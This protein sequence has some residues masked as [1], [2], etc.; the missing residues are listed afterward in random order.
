MRRGGGKSRKSDNVHTF[1]CK[2]A[3]SESEMKKKKEM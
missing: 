2:D 3:E 1:P